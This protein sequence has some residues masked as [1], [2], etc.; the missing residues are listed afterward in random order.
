MKKKKKKLLYLF[1][2][3]KKKHRRSE[4]G[5]GR[6]KTFLLVEKT[7]KKCC[8]FY[9]RKL[10]TY[11]EN[12]W[13]APAQGSFRV[14][15]QGNL[16]PTTS[17]SLFFTVLHK[18]EECFYF[19]RDKKFIRVDRRTVFANTFANTTH[20]IGYSQNDA[21]SRTAKMTRVRERSRSLFV[22]A[23]VREHCVRERSRT[24]VCRL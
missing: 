3:K 13:T 8:D 1:V 18:I 16:W 24:F 19:F 14:W 6:S 17:H 11:S 7:L 10:K 20:F 15:T 2:W 5:E 9:S 4:T 21:C 23:N 22:F 12:V